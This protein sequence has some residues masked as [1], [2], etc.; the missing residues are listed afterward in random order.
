MVINKWFFKDFH[1]N[2]YNAFYT[3]TLPFCTFS[4]L[5]NPRYDLIEEFFNYVKLDKNILI[6]IGETKGPFGMTINPN[7]DKDF[8]ILLNS[9]N[10]AFVFTTDIDETKY[11]IK[12]VLGGIYPI[13]DINHVYIKKLGLKKYAINPNLDDLL[14]KVTYFSK[15]SYGMSRNIWFLSQKYRRQVEKWNNY[16]SKVY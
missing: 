8:N 2:L 7:N 3:K 13:C 12:S 6:N 10:I 9:I 4:D 16:E 14:K 5:K 15:R 11:L 1:N